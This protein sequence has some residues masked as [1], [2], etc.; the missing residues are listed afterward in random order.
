M[1]EYQMATKLEKLLE[2][3]KA[4]QAKLEALEKETEV[5]KQVVEVENKINEKLAGLGDTVKTQVKNIVEQAFVEADVTLPSGRQVQMTYTPDGTVTFSI[6]ELKMKK[7]ATAK[8]PKTGDGTDADKAGAARGKPVKVDGVTYTSSADACKQ[9]GLVI[10]G[11]SAPRV[12]E[13]AKKKGTI[14]TIE[15]V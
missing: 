12:L 4:L 3:Q 7:E 11:D 1:E 2:T 6:V 10:G 5:E 13:R 14:K 15:Y 9:L 8:T